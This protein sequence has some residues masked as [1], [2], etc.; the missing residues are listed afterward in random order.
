MR[1]HTHT[2]THTHN[3]KNRQPFHSIPFSAFECSVWEYKCMAL[4]ALANVLK[5]NIQ[6]CVNW[7]ELSIQREKKTH[8]GKSLTWA[9]VCSYAERK[10]LNSKRKADRKCRNAIELVVSVK[11]QYRVLLVSKCHSSRHTKNELVIQL[12][13]KVCSERDREREMR[14]KNAHYP[15]VRHFV[16][17]EELFASKLLWQ[18]ATTFWYVLNTNRN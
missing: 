4:K 3:R 13:A 8:I 15:F 1:T 12:I 14:E 18:L 6:K 9:N 2:Q 16:M 17:L 7:S 10:L 11:R 5:C